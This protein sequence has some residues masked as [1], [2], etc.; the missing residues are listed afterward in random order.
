MK[1]SD[2]QRD[3]IEGFFSGNDANAASH[4]IGDEVLTAEQ[5][6]GIYRGSV[7]GILTQA[8][9]LTFPVCKSL[10]GEKF[11]DQMCTLF[12]NQYPPSTSFFAEYG[13][14]FAKF[15]SD[16]EPLN[17]IPYI[18]DIAQL[19]WARHEVS[20]KVRKESFDFGKLAEL[21]EESQANVTFTL[22]DTLRLLQSNYRIDEVWFAHQED[23]DIQ[24]ELIE[25]VKP[26]K[27][28]IWK[29]SDQ[30]KISLIQ[31]NTQ[32]HLFWDFLLAISKGKKLGEL[33]IQF[34]DELP[35]LLN[36]GIQSG[37]IQ[38]FE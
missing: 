34:G 35:T 2:I 4:I 17:Q 20:H 11:F 30:L 5:R 31:K 32:D 26:V 28:I 21:N 23:S 29:D 16:Y 10:V 24:L 37:W 14:H 6:F 19:E 15:L 7:H 18:T 1:L 25:L 27:L 3:F 13:N 22:A 9:A 33:A 12:I 8:L 38:S 36:Q